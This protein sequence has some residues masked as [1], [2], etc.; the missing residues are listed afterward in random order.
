[1]FPLLQTGDIPVN[2]GGTAVIRPLHEIHAEG[3]FI[4]GRCIL[5][6]M[7][8]LRCGCTLFI[9]DAVFGSPPQA[10]CREEVTGIA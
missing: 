10:K 2:K 4:F 6:Q 7:K 9:G 1:M 8:T 3:F 5:F